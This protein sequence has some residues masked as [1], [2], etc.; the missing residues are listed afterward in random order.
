MF[1][2]EFLVNGRALE[3]CGHIR[4]GIDE[5]LVPKLFNF[6]DLK[7]RA[8]S[9]F[10]PNYDLLLEEIDDAYEI[11]FAAQRELQRY[12]TRAE[13]L[14]DGADHV[15]E[16]RAHAVHLVHKANARHTVLVSL[17]PHC[18]RLRLHAG[19]GIEHANRSVQHT[20][21]TLNFY[22]EVHVARS[23]NNVDAI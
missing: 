23:I 1:F 2:V 9:F 4:A 7:L 21:R 3:R 15:I 6:K 17:A 5:S 12:R 20:Q 10:E 18:F 8:E 16:I 13:A 22:G 14:L 19:D 11:V